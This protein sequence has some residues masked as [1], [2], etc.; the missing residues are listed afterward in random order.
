MAEFNLAEKLNMDFVEEYSTDVMTGGR[1]KRIHL[2]YQLIRSLKKAESV[3]IIVSF[4]MESGVKMLLDELD[5]ALQRGARKKR[6]V[7]IGAQG[8]A[9]SRDRESDTGRADEGCY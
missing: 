4:L 2:Y 5:N 3:D 1:D 9:E 6:R 7:S 8:R